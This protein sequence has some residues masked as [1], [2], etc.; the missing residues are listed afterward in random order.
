MNR[1]V[2]LPFAALFAAPVYAGCSNYVDGSLPDPAPKATICYRGVCEDTTLVYECGNAHGASAGFASGWRF[3]VGEAGTFIERGW[4]LPVEKGGDLIHRPGKL[5][6]K[7]EYDEI[8]CAMGDG[9][10]CPVIGHAATFE[11]S[12]FY[13]DTAITL[14]NDANMACRQGEKRDGTA[15]SPEESDAE[16]RRR[17]ILTLILKTH[18]YCFNVDEYEWAS[19]R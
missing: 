3:E 11:G 8:T 14:W 7:S 5:V 2:A 13:A 1:V 6:P 16:C 19:C 15:V 4:S 17:E 18:G 12:D 10:P 9:D